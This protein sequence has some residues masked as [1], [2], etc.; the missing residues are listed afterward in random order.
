MVAIK[1]RK[2]FDALSVRHLDFDSESNSD[3]K[4]LSQGTTVIIITLLLL[5]LAGV[6]VCVS[7]PALRT[8]ARI[9][10]DSCSFDNQ[11]E[12]CPSDCSYFFDAM[13][14]ALVNDSSALYSLQRAFFP[15]G[16]QKPRVVDIY[17]TLIL[18]QAI[19][20]SCDS[21]RNI[22]RNETIASL[23]RQS[24]INVCNSNSEVNCTR[25]EYRWH[26]VW[27]S[28]V[29]TRTIERESLGLLSSINSIAYITLQ[30]SLSQTSVIVA[31][32]RTEFQPR[33]KA[34]LEL[35]IPSLHCLPKEPEMTLKNAWEE[36]L[37]WVCNHN[38]NSVKLISYI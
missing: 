2:R 8:C 30:Y 33:E 21:E 34:F 37:P 25:K 28:S 5:N 9:P 29:L 3:S 26:H 11:S 1:K 22:F 23:N 38:N 36:I 20:L 6:Q 13:E 31:T 16:E 27:T 7:S 19:D 18:E 15:N 4:M 35:I 10:F 32:E 17:M 12:E 14:A 24:V